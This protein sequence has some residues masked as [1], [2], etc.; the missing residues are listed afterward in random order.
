MGVSKVDILARKAGFLKAG[1]I[2][3][4]ADPDKVEELGGIEII[5]SP[6]LPEGYSAF[7]TKGGAMVIPPNGKP[8]FIPVFGMN[9]E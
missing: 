8:F 1:E 3:T 2:S 5:E 7:K 9:D 4:C 6:Y